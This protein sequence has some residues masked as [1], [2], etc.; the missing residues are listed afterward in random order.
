MQHIL[1]A[2]PGYPALMDLRVEEM[3]ATGHIVQPCS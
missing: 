3:E 2:H 1:S